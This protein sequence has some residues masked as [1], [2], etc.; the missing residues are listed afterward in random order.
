MAAGSGTDVVFDVDGR[1]YR[2]D[3]GTATTL[4]EELRRAARGQLGDDGYEAA[5]Y[6]VA[7]AIEDVLVG[8]SAGP[9]VLED[10]AVDAVFY[11][12]DASASPSEGERE[13][14]AAVRAEHYRLQEL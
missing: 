12:L 2:L 3:E 10:D 14:Y 4:G 8:N 13:L 1:T 5:A 6:S 7:D 11:H 9:I